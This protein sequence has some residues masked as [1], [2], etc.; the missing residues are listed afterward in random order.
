MNLI[1]EASELDYYLLE[2][3]D[4]KEKGSW[5]NPRKSITKDLVKAGDDEGRK[6]ILAN[7]I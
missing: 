6:L 4:M 1:R 2:V 7:K 5:I 3:A